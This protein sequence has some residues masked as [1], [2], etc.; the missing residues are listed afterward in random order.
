[1]R[2]L[3]GNR[4]P[5]WFKLWDEKP[6]RFIQ[7]NLTDAF[8]NA[9]SGSPYPL[10]YSGARGIYTGL[11]PNMGTVLLVADYQTYVDSA[12]TQ[13]DQGYLP[14]CDWLEPDVGPPP[15]LILLNRPIK[16]TLY[17]TKII[18]KISPTRIKVRIEKR[19]LIAKVQS[20]ELNAVVQQP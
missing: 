7:A 12:Y 20:L 2:I 15:Q 19:N 5:F 13:I 8:G 11:G 10:T 17:P 6:N 14:A 18:A 9:Q 4:I 3:P 16:A 1:M